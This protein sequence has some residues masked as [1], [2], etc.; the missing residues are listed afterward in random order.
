MG[1]NVVK[2]ELDAVFFTRFGAT[3]SFKYVEFAKQQDAAAAEPQYL[4]LLFFRVWDCRS[5]ELPGLFLLCVQSAAGFDVQTGI[6][7]GLYKVQ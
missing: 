3:A 2:S 7:G 5:A 1:D 6:G 4:K